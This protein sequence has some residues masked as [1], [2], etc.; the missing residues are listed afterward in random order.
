MTRSRFSISVEIPAPPS[1]VWSVMADVERWPE[2]TASV[3]RVKRLT[4]GPLREG[5]RMRIHQPK[6]PPALWRV[7]ELK[8]DAGFTGVSKA[9]GVRV[10]AR[11]TVEPVDTGSRVTLSI[12]Y[13]GFLGPLL[14]RW[15]G[16]MNDRY[17][18]MEAAGLRTKCVELLGKGPESILLRQKHY[19]GQGVQGPKSNV[20]GRGKD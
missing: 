4:P 14:A 6:L 13:E 9:P 7:I 1:L 17:L 15:V 11:H 19:G 10:V 18:A 8:P 2:W 3:S 12:C 20:Q 16:G 5:S